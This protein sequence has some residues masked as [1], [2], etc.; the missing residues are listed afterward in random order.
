MYID[1]VNMMHDMGKKRASKPKRLSKATID[2]FDFYEEILNP[3]LSDLDEPVEPDLSKW[4]QSLSPEH[5]IARASLFRGRPR[6]PRALIHLLSQ[7]GRSELVE[8]IMSALRA[9][10]CHSKNRIVNRKETIPVSRVLS[11]V[12]EYRRVVRFF[13]LHFC[14]ETLPPPIRVCEIHFKNQPFYDLEDGN[15]RTEAAKMLGRRRIAAEIL[16]TASVQLDEWRI[17]SGALRHLPSGELHG[18]E[19]D[20]LAAAAWLGVKDAS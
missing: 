5:A 12:W 9:M 13:R 3:L 8:P 2:G 18:H 4:R 19:V 7:E 17:V 16:C 15:H 14:A 10:R 20:V 1:A 11:H 6:Q